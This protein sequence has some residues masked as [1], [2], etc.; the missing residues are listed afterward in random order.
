MPL[1]CHNRYKEFKVIVRDNTSLRRALDE[2]L[3]GKPLNDRQWLALINQ[4]VIRR[5]WEVASKRGGTES[6]LEQLTAVVQQLRTAWGE[7]QTA[8]SATRQK[9]RTPLDR[10][11]EAQAAAIAAV[12]SHEPLLA[13]FR[14]RFLAGGVMDEAQAVAWL[15]EQAREQSGSTWIEDIAKW[16]EANPDRWRSPQRMQFK[17]LFTPWA[18]AG[19]LY[20]VR[21]SPL[22]RL[23]KLANHLGMLFGVSSSEAVRVI[24]TGQPPR[25]E[26]LRI[27]KQAPSMNLD[28]QVIWPGLRIRIECSPLVTPSEVARQLRA[29]RLK[30]FGGKTRTLSARALELAKFV[31]GR[32]KQPWSALMREW[33][34][35]VARRRPEWRYSLVQNFSRDARRALDRLLRPAV[36]DLECLTSQVIV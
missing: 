16:T 14:A 25:I 17:F 2:R 30:T 5:F 13:A 32:P 11:M 3:P 1:L 36:D 19:F 26:A 18:D 29:W 20:C 23:R 34:K 27:M 31:S 12:I 15:L 22:D 28:G 6:A 24:L 33:N 4:G 10:L 8:P 21:G 9:R 35:A 7:A